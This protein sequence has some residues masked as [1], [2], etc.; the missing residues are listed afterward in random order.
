MESLSQDV[1]SQTLP[2]SVYSEIAQMQSQS[3]APSLISSHMT[4]IASENGDGYR[5]EG[6]LAVTAP[7]QARASVEVSPRPASSQRDIWNISSASRRGI[8][9]STVSG[10]GRGI[11]GFGGP[12]VSM[13]NSSRPQS[14]GSRTSRASRT[15]VPSL[16]SHAFFRPM[17]SQRLQAQRGGRPLTSGQS[18][19]TGFGNGEI[20]G[21]DLSTNGKP[22]QVDHDLLPPSRGTDITENDPRDRASINASPTGDATIRS[23]GESTRPLH[24]TSS[25]LKQPYHDHITHTRQMNGVDLNN[26]KPNGSFRSSFLLPS[27]RVSQDPIMAKLH[28][29]VHAYS[30]A[31]SPPFAEQGKAIQHRGEGGRNHQHFS[32]NTVFFGGGRIQNTR[33]RPINIA[34]GTLVVLPSII[35]FVFS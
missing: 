21:M 35:F 29:N 6:P 28:N 27:R 11:K 16:T 1:N 9:S 19:D 34:T 22:E 5:S 8:I 33:E 24:S 26:P 30:N 4:D 7:S 25:Y 3:Q 18:L 13:S 31:K 10:N 17:S 23:V 2:N 20:H 12:G 15:H 32:G 14:S